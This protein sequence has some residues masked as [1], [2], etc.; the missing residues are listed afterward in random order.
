ML[1]EGGPGFKTIQQDVRS[2]SQT[3]FDS[4]AM[5]AEAFLMRLKSSALMDKFLLMM[6]QS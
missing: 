6:D 4:L 3:L 5:A 2:F 1:H